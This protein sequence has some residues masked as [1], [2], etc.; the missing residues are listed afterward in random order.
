VKRSEVR[1]GFGRRVGLGLLAVAMGVSAC[2]AP[3]DEALTFERLGEAGELVFELSME[4]VVEGPNELELWVRDASTHDLVDVELSVDALHV[5]MG[6]GSDVPPEILSMRDGGY[7]VSGLSFA[8][9][10]RWTIL[11]DARGTTLSD[12]LEFDVVVR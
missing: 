10:G 2:Q 11:V 8:M 9:P 12:H 3:I 5:E 1:D 6:H 4:R 7:L